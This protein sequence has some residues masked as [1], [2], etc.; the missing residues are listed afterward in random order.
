MNSFIYLDI[1]TY[2]KLKS[3]IA[4]KVPLSIFSSLQLSMDLEKE[5]VFIGI[6]SIYGKTPAEAYTQRKMSG[7][8]LNIQRLL[9]HLTHYKLYY[10]LSATTLQLLYRRCS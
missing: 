4:W 3:F 8:T 2:R 6:L 10:V 1:V 9:F 5:N 7:R